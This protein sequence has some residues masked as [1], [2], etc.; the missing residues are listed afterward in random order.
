ML[1]YRQ[2]EVV[3]GTPVWVDRTGRELASIVDTSLERLSNVRLSPE[4][5]R[6]AAVVAGDLWVYDLTG[7]PPIKLTFDGGNDMPF[8]TPDGQRLVYAGKVPRMGL[9]SV[10][11]VQGGTPEPISPVGHYHPHAWAPDGA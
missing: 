11:A 2:R 8:W 5:N 10:A 3:S 4:G 6:L 1:A 9:L 7:R